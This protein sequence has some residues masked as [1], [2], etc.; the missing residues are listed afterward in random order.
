MSDSSY[1]NNISQTKNDKKSYKDI[2]FIC[3]YLNSSNNKS[4]SNSKT[5]TIDQE[6]SMKSIDSNQIISEE[7][8][9]FSA[10]DNFNEI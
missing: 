8:N 10:F 7:E 5:K 2:N 3:N 9:L 1:I 4:L 6:I